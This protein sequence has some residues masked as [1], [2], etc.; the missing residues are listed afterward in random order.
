VRNIGGR[1]IRPAEYAPLTEKYL[2]QHPDALIYVATD[3]P[4]FL[5]E[6]KLAHADRL[7]VY[8]ALR[9]ERNVFADRSVSNNFKKGEDALVEAL[10]LSCSNFVVKPASALSEFA[11]YFAPEL[12]NHTIE[13]QYAK[14]RPDPDAVFAAHWASARDAAR[15]WAR[16][17]QMM[18]GVD[19][20]AWK[21]NGRAAAGPPAA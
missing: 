20:A 3:S 12:H 2:R 17:A 15:G 4:S 6:V 19:D 16:C 18:G 9:S 1:V 14:G 7:V 5:A 11:V 13:L 21:V 8:D 10:L